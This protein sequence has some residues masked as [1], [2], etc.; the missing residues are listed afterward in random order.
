MQIRFGPVTVRSSFLSPPW[1]NAWRAVERTF[2]EFHGMEFLESFLCYRRIPEYCIPVPKHVG[3]WYLSVILFCYVRLLVDVLI[4]RLCTVCIELNKL[5]YIC[6]YSGLIC[7]DS[8][9]L[10]RPF[11]VLMHTKSSITSYFLIYLT[12]MPLNIKIKLPTTIPSHNEMWQE[13][14]IYLTFKNRASYI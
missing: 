2:T 8:E 10:I 13:S 9:S 14:N 12:G 6:M 1:K 4:I 11:I 5:N 7:R 3:V